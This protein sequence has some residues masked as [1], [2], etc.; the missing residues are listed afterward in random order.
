MSTLREQIREKLLLFLALGAVAL[1]M[2]YKLLHEV[3]P[4]VFLRLDSSYCRRGG[5][6][7][8]AVLGLGLG[9][10][11]GAVA[12]QR[13]YRLPRLILAA[14]AAL[15]L[16]LLGVSQLGEIGSSIAPDDSTTTTTVA[17]DDLAA[18]SAAAAEIPADAMTPAETAPRMDT[19]STV[20]EGWHRVS[21]EATALQASWLDSLAAPQVALAA[22]DM[23]RLLRRTH[24][25]AKVA[26]S[27]PVRTGWLR[28]AAL[29][30][31]F[32]EEP[33]AAEQPAA[34]EPETAAAAPPDPEA[35]EA[36]APTPAPDHPTGHQEHHGMVGKF[37]ATYSLDWQPSGVLSGTY[38]F[39]EQPTNTYRLTGAVAPDGELHLLEFTRGRQ[40]ARCTLQRQEAGY[41]GR[42]YNTDGREFDMTLE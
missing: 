3:A 16:A 1:W 14:A 32:T 10:A 4:V 13:R 39:A 40:S 17:D 5:S 41:S 2:L 33:A 23:V 21:V 38:F 15:V 42:M 24:G 20:A 26:T 34:D 25:W 18:T 37:H 29:G 30:P 12:A 19:I 36:E 8:Y 6:F 28:V 22:G 31:M 35:S 11:A 9:A 7:G 27:V